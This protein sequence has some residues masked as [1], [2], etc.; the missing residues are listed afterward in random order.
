MTNRTQFPGTGPGSHLNTGFAGP[1]APFD[2]H[3]PWDQPEKHPRDWKK[4]ILVVG[5]GSLSWVA[6]YVGMLELIQAN[7]G[8][9]PITHK[10]IIGFSVAMLMTMII[11]LLD[12]L[13]SPAPFWQKI[14]YAGGYLFLTLISVGFGFGFYWKVLESRSEATRS[15][16]SAVSQVQTAMHAGSTRLEQLNTTL[17]QLTRVSSAKAQEERERGTSCPNSRPGDGPRRKLRDSDAEKFAFASQFVAERIETLRSDL[18]SFDQELAKIASDDPSTVDDKTGTRNEFMRG[19]DRRLDMAVAGFN[20]FKTDPQLLQIRQDLAARAEKTIFPNGRG[21]SFSCPDA[22]LQSALRGVVLA[23]DQIPQLGDVKVAAVEGS[24]ATIEAFRRLAASLVGFVQFQLPPSPD[25]LRNLQRQAVQ[26]MATNAQGQP[27]ASGEGLVQAGLSKRDYIPLAIAVFV[28]LCLLLVSMGRPMNRF[29]GLVT[30]MREAER[31]PVIRILSRFNDIHR[32]PDV[33]QNFE[34][35]RHVVFDFN[36]AYYV[37]VPLDTPY[38]RVDPRS[39]RGTSYGASDAQDL[40]HEAHLLANLF[41]SFEKEKIFTRVYS[42]LLTTGMIQKRLARQGSKF[43]G[44]RAFRLYRFKDGA[45]SDIILGAVMGAARRVE[46]E[47]R[48]A[49]AL[50]PSPMQTPGEVE[51]GGAATRAGDAPTDHEREP[52]AERGVPTADDWSEAALGQRAGRARE[53]AF[54]DGL[55]GTRVDLPVQH[56]SERQAYGG[57]DHGRPQHGR[58]TFRPERRQREEEAEIGFHE[59]FRGKGAEPAIRADHDHAAFASQFGD[60]ARS[61]HAEL[62]GVDRGVKSQ[63][64]DRL[65]AEG[66]GGDLHDEDRSLQD[67]PEDDFETDVLRARQSFA[68]NNTRPSQRGAEHAEVGSLP[69]D[70]RDDQGNRSGPVHDDGAEVIALPQRAEGKAMRTAVRANATAAGSQTPVAIGEPA[71]AA[72]FGVQRMGHARSDAAAALQIVPP[73]LPADMTQ[74]TVTRET[75]TFNVPVSEARMPIIEAGSWAGDGAGAERAEGERA[76]TVRPAGREALETARIA[77]AEASEADPVDDGLIQAA[78][79]DDFARTL[80]LRLR[81]DNTRT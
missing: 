10:V 57:Q 12:Q 52:F 24:E 9:L 71:G 27:T 79:D 65:S 58:K 43:A 67:W 30:K 44:S 46:Q 28:D 7:M 35:F 40:Q 1:N 32:D 56:R 75:A 6:T 34:V 68:N 3:E 73:P 23:I 72:G 77:P 8:E 26:S 17:Q 31:G 45:W 60:Y 62:S 16:Q 48:R 61:A 50:N 76:D 63:N 22:Q 2:D 59:S 54:D 53:E 11:W 5:L 49:A 64:R 25:D 69:S 19:L 21:G 18:A 51:A 74:V 41:A 15:A 81:P 78:S 20:A 13:F 47:K 66:H 33:R 14:A 29:G 37:A 39:G 80:A 55:A 42:P 4:V 36:G 38:N 70:V